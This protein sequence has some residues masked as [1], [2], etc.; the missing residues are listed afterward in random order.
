MSR[1]IDVPVSHCCKK[2]VITRVPSDVTITHHHARTQVVQ[3]PNGP[4][5]H[6]CSQCCERC[7]VVLVKMSVPSGRSRRQRLEDEA[8]RPTLFGS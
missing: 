3:K 7:Q 8:D 5:Y 4:E 1:Q 2:P 6:I